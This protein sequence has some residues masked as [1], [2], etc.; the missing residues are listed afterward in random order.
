MAS[1]PI[2]S[3]LI[4]TIPQRVVQIVTISKSSAITSLTEVVTCELRDEASE[5]NM[6]FQSW[7]LQSEVRHFLTILGL[8]LNK[9]QFDQTKCL[10]NFT[11]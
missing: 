5:G 10:I 6:G 4:A 7:K 8:C 3:S 11:M 9:T 1:P 2:P